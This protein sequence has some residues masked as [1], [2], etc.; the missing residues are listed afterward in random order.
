MDSE[1]NSPECNKENL[2]KLSAFPIELPVSP[3]KALYASI[4]N[5]HDCWL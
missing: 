5:R 4:D 3:E 2:G 1:S